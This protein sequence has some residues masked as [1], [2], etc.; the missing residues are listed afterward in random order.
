MVLLLLIWK[1]KSSISKEKGE[2]S[3]HNFGLISHFMKLQDMQIE[4]CAISICG[5]ITVGAGTR[6]LLQLDDTNTGR[7]ELEEE[8][9]PISL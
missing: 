1:E 8:V 2:V 9:A 4:G 5:V 7:K 6:E 3:L